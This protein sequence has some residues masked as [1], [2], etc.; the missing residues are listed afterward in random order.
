MNNR[1]VLGAAMCAALVAGAAGP[2][3]AEVPMDHHSKTQGVVIDDPWARATPGRSGNG[4]AYFKVTNHGKAADRVVAAVSPVARRA[5][6]HAHIKEGGVMRMR[7][8]A[9]VDLAPGA[10]AVFEPGGYHVMLMGLKEPLKQG[11]RFP[12]TLRFE[13]AGDID[14]TVTVGAIGAMGPHGA[15]PGGHH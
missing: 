2:M 9:G 1:I 6:L 10:S 14:V 12:L 7:K 3:R 8:V 5:E 11:A 13:K 4:A 15:H